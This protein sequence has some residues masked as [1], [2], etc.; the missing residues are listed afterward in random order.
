MESI[1]EEG[2]C[3]IQF[4]KFKYT[5]TIQHN[6]WVWKRTLKQTYRWFI[7]FKETESLL[8]QK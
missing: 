3:I 1:Q 4:A 5:V 2:Q 6:F 7:Q 8:K